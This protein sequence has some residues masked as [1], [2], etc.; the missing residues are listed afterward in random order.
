MVID[1]SA[2]IALVRGGS[3]SGRFERALQEAFPHLVAAPTVT[4]ASIV[5]LSRFGEAGLDDLHALIA[6]TA[7]DIVPFTGT[8]A[9][10]AI[11][12][13]RQFGKGRHPAGLNFGNCFSYALAKG[14][15]ER[16]FKGD[17]FSRTGV[18]RAV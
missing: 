4:E 7:L 16:L 15:G 13:F 12:G 8:H 1:S 2:L 14:T 17:D 5:M 6:E 10:L 9:R 11:E 3:E 18:K